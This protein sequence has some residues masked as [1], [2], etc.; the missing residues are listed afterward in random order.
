MLFLGFSAGVPILLI[1]STLSVWLREAGVA[2][3][4]VTF[5][6]WA[7]LGYSFKFLWAPLVDLLP[8]PGLTRTLGRRRAWL[9]VA[10]LFI[11]AAIVGMALVDPVAGNHNLTVMAFA[12]VMLG[13]SSATQ[14]IVIDAYRIESAEESLQAMLAAMYI[15]GYRVGMLVAGAG[16]LFLAGYLGTTTEAYDYT[17]WKTT[18]MAMAA[19]MGSGVA[20]TLFI[21]E[22]ETSRLVSHY[23]YAVVDYGRF[24]SFFVLSALT[25]ALTFF[26]SGFLF[27]EVEKVLAHVFVAGG[28]IFSFLVELARFVLAVGV[29]AIVAKV[30]LFVGLVNKEM[31][32]QTYLEPIKDFFFRYGGKTALLLLVLIGFYR[33]S[34]I[35]LGVVSNVFYL[36]MGFSK[37]VIAGVTKTFGL[38]MILLGGF[39]GGIL[40][41]RFGVHK[42]L[43]LGAFL[44]A[45]TNLLFM[46][47]ARTGADV[48]MLT[49][50]I[51]ADNLSAGI[52]T[53]AFIA[54]L[55]SLTNI[56][57]TAVQ[58]AIFSSMMTLFP[59]LIGGYSGTMVS[60][61]GYERFFMVTALMGIPVLFLVVAARKTVLKK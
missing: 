7:A 50:V 25:F 46:L 61:F 19:V 48:S 5:F 14:D 53:T 23:T 4:A 58:Y 37:N 20:T 10:Q 2:R 13:F 30:M 6:S 60:N 26:F 11:I 45:A 1:F 8:L 43:F 22:P 44:S 16:S 35:V 55:S 49:V 51:G 21:H 31:V 47:L 28:E 40:T 29:A 9:L 54:F 41:V 27:I 18:Y 17:A 3:S 33:L 34:D 24:L 15:A 12:A 52:A 36:D 38:A 56:S 39:L 42:I 59:K 57:F 32:H